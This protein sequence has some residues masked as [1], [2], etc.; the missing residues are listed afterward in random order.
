MV[1]CFPA[2]APRLK[3]FRFKN[4]RNKPSGRPKTNKDGHNKYSNEEEEKRKKRESE[5]SKSNDGLEIVE[6]EGEMVVD[7]EEGEDD[8]VKRKQESTDCL[9]MGETGEGKM[10]DGEQ[11]NIDN[12]ED[13]TVE[14]GLKGGSEEFE[15]ARNTDTSSSDNSESSS[16][17]LVPPATQKKIGKK[18]GIC[19]TICS[20]REEQVQHVSVH[21]PIKPFRCSVCQY[22]TTDYQQLRAHLWKHKLIGGD[23]QKAH[24]KEGLDEMTQFN[25]QYLDIC[26]G[27]S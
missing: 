8:Q 27:Q 14:E 25:S 7:I 5:E 26:F 16:K 12:V 6:E 3:K 2:I 15:I 18:C 10:D 9:D 1:R 11:T 20:T 19:G 24:L 13:A 17:Q 4:F 23:R 21:V 22:R